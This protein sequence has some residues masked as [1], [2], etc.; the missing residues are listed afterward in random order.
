MAVALG[1]VLRKIVQTAEPFISTELPK[2][3]G[4]SAEI[5]EA[6][7]RSKAGILCLT[8][9]NL[10][11]PWINYE[12]GALAH[13][14]R[15]AVCTLLLDI[16]PG[17]LAG[18]PLGR[19]QHTNASSEED[20]VRMFKT[21]ATATFGNMDDAD[22]ADLVHMFWPDLSKAFA[23]ARLTNASPPRPPDQTAMIA[24][25]LDAVRE[26]RRNTIEL[27]PAHPPDQIGQRGGPMPWITS[28]ALRSIVLQ[29]PPTAA[30]QASGAVGPI[31]YFDE[32]LP[33]GWK[34][35]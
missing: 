27:P 11:E 34:G 31:V 18:L 19:F 21:I 17:H 33:E 6:L 10:H 3:S 25:I 7:G 20:V 26:I 2:G 15:Q 16:E 8:S 5:H 22:L 28:G 4:W 13:T 1:P 30:E 24:E 35:K 9:E 14:T 23:E 29:R 12:G 32:G